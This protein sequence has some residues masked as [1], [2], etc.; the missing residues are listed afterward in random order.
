MTYYV[1]YND[2]FYTQLASYFVTQKDFQYVHDDTEAFFY[3]PFSVKFSV[4][5]RASNSYLSF[6]Y[7]KEKSKKIFY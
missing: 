6:L 2:F 5:S 1:L 4:L 7:R 3:F